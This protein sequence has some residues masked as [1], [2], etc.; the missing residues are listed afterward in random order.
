MRCFRLRLGVTKLCSTA[1]SGRAQ[2]SGGTVDA[3][4]LT[5]RQVTILLV[6]TTPSVDLRRSTFA[7]LL[8][9]RSPPPRDIASTFLYSTGLNRHWTD[10]AL[11]LILFGSASSL[12]VCSSQAP[13]LVTAFELPSCH[14]SWGLPVCS[15]CRPLQPIM[16]VSGTADLNAVLLISLGSQPIAAC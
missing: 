7:H 15:L 2:I 9:K 1:R 13:L 12:L 8:E 4:D 10:P 16:W 5:F 14:S 11:A 6:A 3:N